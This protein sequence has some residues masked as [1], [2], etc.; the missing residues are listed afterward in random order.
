MEQSQPRT[1]YRNDYRPPDYLI[2]SAELRFELGETGTL[3]RSLL[4]IRRNPQRPDA[5]A[6]LFLDGEGLELRSLR[7]NGATL[8]HDEY[9]A[10]DKGLTVRAVPASFTLASA[11]LIHPEQN[12]ALEGLYRSGGLFCTQCEAEGFRRITYFIDRPDV[13]ARFTVTVVADRELYPV[14]LSNGNLD[15]EGELTNGRHWARWRDPF[16]KPSYLFALVAGRLSCL[17]HDFVTASGRPVALRICVEPRNADKCAHAMTSLLEAMAWDERVYGREYDLDVFHIVAV[18]DFNMGAMENK[19]LNVF[20]SKY[21][22]ARPDT[23]TDEDYS[24]IEGVIAH[25]YFHNWTGNRVTCRD[26]FQL[27]LKEG[28][29]VFRDQEFSSDV[30]SRAV[31]RITDVQGLRVLQFAEDAGPMAHPVRPDAY[32]EI[33]NFYTSTVYNKGAEVVRMIHTLLGP[34]RFRA[35]TDLYFQ[36]HDG[37][38]V[39]CEDFVHAM[40]DASG[41]DLAQFRLWY[42]QAGTPLLRVERCYDP[43]EKA[44]ILEIEQQ[45]PETP[46]QTDK[47][48]MHIP[49]AMALLAGDGSEMPLRLEGEPVAA[50][51]TTR[52][53]ELRERR[54]SFRFVDVES[55]PVPSLLRGFSAPVRIEGAY[56]DADLAFLAAH[57]HDFF[58]RWD[59][60]QQ[61]ALRRMLELVEER[62]A[63][64]PLGLPDD[65]A[66]AFRQT[67]SATDLDEALVAKALV[68]PSEAYV[69]DHMSEVDVDGIHEVRSFLRRSLATQAYEDLLVRYYA[70]RSDPSRG[71]PAQDASAVARRALSNVCLAYL[72]R[73]EGTEAQALPYRQFL[74]ADNMSDSL[75][76]LAVLANLDCPER[77]AALEAFY[78]R[79]KNDPLVVDK[80]LSVQ[81]TSELTGTLDQVRTLTGHEAFDIKNPNKVRALLG[82]FCGANAVRFHD[83]SGAGYR[84]LADQVL[85]LDS[86]NPQVAAR[87]IGTISRWRRYDSQRQALLGSELRRVASHPSLSRDVYEV[88]SKSLS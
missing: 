12:T 3:V 44:L 39:T 13:L 30:G 83:P 77:D 23:A 48:P 59:A 87:M 27:S 66:K 40:E 62:R 26:W 74:G 2:D 34:E 71:Q 18:D 43:A 64:H 29:T 21:V 60:G 86:L 15:G 24:A 72:S 81:A 63:G 7:L 45:C 80:W 52:V 70:G 50:G 84:F 38:A 8:S 31:K 57:D 51:T 4:T 49:L 53:L 61:L 54:H 88:V 68:L 76:A 55:E 67:L 56:D 1:I 6:D 42:S 79:W 73:V 47:Q 5:S 35:G 37:Q 20:N 82:G 33:N 9:E 28:L 58:N 17:E 19:G 16:P 75:A 41:V 25:E 32:I 85:V 78:S 22:L 36:R 69:A 10:G 14:L 65:L 46:G 11:V